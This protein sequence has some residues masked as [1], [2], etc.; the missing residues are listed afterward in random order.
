MGPVKYYPI[1]AASPCSSISYFSL[2]RVRGVCSKIAIGSPSRM[3][4]CVS[5]S[6]ISASSTPIERLLVTLLTH[7]SPAR[8]FSE[9]PH[10]SA[11]LNIQGFSH[12]LSLDFCTDKRDLPKIDFR[13]SIGSIGDPL[14]P[15]ILSPLHRFLL[16]VNYS[17]ANAGYSFKA[18]ARPN[19][20][21]Q[22]LTYR[23]GFLRDTVY[24]GH[25]RFRIR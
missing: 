20:S 2:L 8:D 18:C 4:P 3:L 17:L 16:T 12:A 15:R 9:S 25:C 11:R 10:D 22:C 6:Y 19:S 21:S 1:L 23:L 5:L 7:Q 24:Q 13:C 14:A